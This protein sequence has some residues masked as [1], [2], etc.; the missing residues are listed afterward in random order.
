MA[1]TH[2]GYGTK[3]RLTAPEA[4]TAFTLGSALA[5]GRLDKGVVRVGALGDLAGLSGDPTTVP[6]TSISSL[7]VRF[8][9]VG[10]RVVY[11]APPRS[12][13]ATIAH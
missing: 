9:I 1:V 4:L 7:E 6:P 13:A 3:E 8:T 11:E 2:G 5:E 12:S 10:G